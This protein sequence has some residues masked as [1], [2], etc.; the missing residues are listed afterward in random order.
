MCMYACAYAYVSDFGHVHVKCAFMTYA[1]AYAY[2]SDLEQQYMRY[3]RART[4][5]NKGY[6]HAY[7]LM[8]VYIYMCVHNTIHTHMYV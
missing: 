8:C 7:I 2:V 1:C 4:C 6:I 5:F 3:R